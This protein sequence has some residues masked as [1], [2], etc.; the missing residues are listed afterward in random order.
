MRPDPE[1]YG[2]GGTDCGLPSVI[3]LRVCRAWPAL[4]V[5]R[6][7]EETTGWTIKKS[8]RPAAAAGRVVAHHPTEDTRSGPV[9]PCGP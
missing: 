2:L 4:A 9:R 3:G 5:S 7:I 1:A 8:V 6:R